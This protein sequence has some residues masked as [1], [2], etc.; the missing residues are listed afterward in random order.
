MERAVAIKKLTKLLG[1][2]LGFRVDPKAPDKDERE[3]A[4]LQLKE[5]FPKQVALRQAMDARKAELLRGDAEYQRLADEHKAARKH[6]EKLQA[7]SGQYRFTVG[8]TSSIFFMVKAQGDSW[9]EVI[10]KVEQD[11]K[12]FPALYTDK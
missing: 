5:D 3:G 12:K 11:Q 4:R 9:E 8:T 1:K 10:A 2:H 6:C 7:T